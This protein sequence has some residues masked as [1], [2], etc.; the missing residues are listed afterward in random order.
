MDAKTS[1]RK[2]REKDNFSAAKVASELRLAI[3]R[4]E[5]RVPLSTGKCIGEGR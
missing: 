1:V 2:S 5:A 4:D 3:P